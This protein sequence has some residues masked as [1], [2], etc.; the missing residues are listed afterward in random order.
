M[1]Y[2]PLCQRHL[3]ANYKQY[4]VLKCN[5]KHFY[6]YITLTISSINV[7]YYVKQQAKV[8]I[9]V[10]VVEVSIWLYKA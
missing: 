1:Y 8:M 3:K 10:Q 9:N 5:I 7:G 6:K 4:Y 2:F